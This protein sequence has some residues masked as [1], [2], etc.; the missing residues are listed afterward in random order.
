ML[1]MELYIMLKGIIEP[2]EQYFGIPLVRGLPAIPVAQ[3]FQPTQ[4]GVAVGPTAFLTI[5]GHQPIGQPS[6][7]DV[8]EGD[9]M[10]H[11][12]I[13]QMVTMF[14]ISALATQD[15]K[16]LTQYTAADIINFM[17]MILKNSQTIELLKAEDCG[18]TISKDVQNPKFLDDRGRFESNPSFTFSISHKLI[19]QKSQAVL[20]STELDVYSV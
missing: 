15:S 16:S 14:Q 20:Q 10:I 6:R 11:R 3:N 12:E 7:Q 19:V 4:Q 9:L 18:I 13:Q 1:D 2:A 8:I 17:A 5:I